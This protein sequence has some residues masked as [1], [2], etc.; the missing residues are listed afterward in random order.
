MMNATVKRFKIK[1]YLKFI[2]GKLNEHETML[3]NAP[4]QKWISRSGTIEK[5]K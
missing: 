3:W 4:E 5:D 1:V 2:V